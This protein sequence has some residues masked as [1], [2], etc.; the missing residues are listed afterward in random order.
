V[1][2]VADRGYESYNNIAHLTNKGWHYVIRVKG[3][4]LG[5]GLLSKTSLASGQV[6]DKTISILMTRQQTNKVKNKPLLYRFL[7]KVSTFDFLPHG[8]KDT[9][10]IT[11]RVVCVEIKKGIYQYLITN[12]SKEDFSPDDLKEIYKMRWGIETSF[13]ELKHSIAMTHFHSKK[14]AHIQQEIYAKMILYNFCEM[15]TQEIIIKT[16]NNR[17]HTYKVNFSNAITICKRFFKCCDD[18]RSPDVETLIRKYISPVRAGRNYPR[19]IKTQP[20]KSFL[21][22][23][24]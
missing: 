12:L 3:P 6:Y 15:I 8:S 21:Y 16:D 14:V 7:A 2:L 13:R 19:N 9:Y 10:P 5:N 20:N 11:Y 4:K 17:K 18:R 1:I 22:R 23:V 24:S